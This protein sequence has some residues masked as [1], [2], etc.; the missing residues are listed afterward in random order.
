MS[1]V[2]NSLLSGIVALVWTLSSEK[3]GKNMNIS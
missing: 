3:S 1:A 2:I